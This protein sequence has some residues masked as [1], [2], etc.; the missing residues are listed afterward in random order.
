MTIE[1]SQNPSIPK[2]KKSGE[3]PHESPRG[4]WHP[5]E[6]VE[7]IKSNKI[8]TTEYF[9]L[10]AIDNY[11]N[12]KKQGCWASDEYLAN[13]VKVTT[14]HIQRMCQHLI[15]IGFVFT[16]VRKTDGRRILAT[17]WFLF[18]N[19]F[20]LPNVDFN[21]TSKNSNQKDEEIPA[22]SSSSA[23]DINVQSP[24]HTSS[25]TNDINVASPGHICRKGDRHI[26]HTEVKEDIVLGTNKSEYTVGREILPENEKPKPI[27]V[28]DD[29]ILSTAGGKLAIKFFKGLKEKD[30]VR[31]TPDLKEW[32]K[33]FN[34]L[35][36][37]IS[38]SN[39]TTEVGAKEI[40][41]TQ[42]S[43]HLDHI[44]DDYWPEIYSAKS[45][46]IDKYDKLVSAIARLKKDETV[47]KEVIIKN[48]LFQMARSDCEVEGKFRIYKNGRME[49]KRGNGDWDWIEKGSERDWAVPDSA[50]GY[51][52]YLKGKY[53][54]DRDGWE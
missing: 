45:F 11:S 53:H 14:R 13:E 1:Q 32:S 44:S 50:I 38:V 40:I 5:Q 9:L 3:T 31:R 2:K 37:E 27:F 28:G 15:S 20:S 42:I 19:G 17:K 12:W 36:K 10:G 7:A 47:D 23:L 48:K 52:R 54:P 8:T 4:R 34:D 43:T 21:F 16:G 51:I 39:K 22:S 6:Q 29:Q 30:L 41:K 49:R 33:Y 26:C 25:S 18:E 46:C 24:G 35:V